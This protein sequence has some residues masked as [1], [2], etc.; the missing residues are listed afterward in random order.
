MGF[1][2]LSDPATAGFDASSAFGG[3]SMDDKVPPPPAFEEEESGNGNMK[4]KT[5]SAKSSPVI[6]SRSSSTKKNALRKS[7]SME[8]ESPSTPKSGSG[9]RVPRKS[10]SK[11]ADAAKAPLDL[12]EGKAYGGG[13]C[14][15]T[16]HLQDIEAFCRVVKAAGSQQR[17]RLVRHS[18]M[19]AS[20][21]TTSNQGSKKSSKAAAFK[22]SMTTAN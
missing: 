3:L 5:S 11:G 12:D 9:K 20:T 15:M 4:R 18:M 21:G 16:E 10:R 22:R 19:V 17:E 2:K 1:F 7:K 13:S 14:E 6:T 8:A